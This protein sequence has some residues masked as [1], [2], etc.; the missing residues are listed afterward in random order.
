MANA[1]GKEE[2]KCKYE[3]DGTIHV[4]YDSCGNIKVCDCSSLF[5]MSSKVVASSWSSLR[6]ARPPVL[7]TVSLPRPVSQKELRR[8]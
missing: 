3:A 1:Q 6:N 8:A 7:A 4:R 5:S 2:C